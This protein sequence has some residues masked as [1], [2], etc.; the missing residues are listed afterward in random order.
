MPRTE[1]LK[2]DIYF[3]IVLQAEKSKITGPAGLVLGELSLPGLCTAAISLCVFC[4]P[5]PSKA[6]IPSW[7]FYSH[8]LVQRNYI[9]KAATPNTITLDIRTSTYKF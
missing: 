1:W 2:E 4:L 5:L 6:F 3:L 8:N 7:E 9:S